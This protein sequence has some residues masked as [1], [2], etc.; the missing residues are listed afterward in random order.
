MRAHH[1]AHATHRPIRH[2][3]R[4]TL[5]SG[6]SQLSVLRSSRPLLATSARDTSLR[7]DRCSSCNARIPHFRHRLLLSRPVCAALLARSSRTNHSSGDVSHVSCRNCMCV[8]HA[9]NY[10]TRRGQS[11]SALRRV[12]EAGYRTRFSLQ[13]QAS[14]IGHGREV[15]FCDVRIS[16][17]ASI[18]LDS[19]AESTSWYFRRFTFHPRC[20]SRQNFGTGHCCVDRVHSR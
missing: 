9:H 15:A 14:K 8:F 6:R 17:P 3:R 10:N 2:I 20:V 5:H 12:S 19:E 1:L 13:T 16:A 4:S 11:R 7:D 18:R